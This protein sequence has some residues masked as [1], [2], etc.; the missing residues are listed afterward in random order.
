M[1]RIFLGLVVVKMNFMCFGGFLMSLS[2]V[3]KFCGVIMCVL[4]RMKI[5]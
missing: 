5:L 1:L 3:L 2:S 4:L